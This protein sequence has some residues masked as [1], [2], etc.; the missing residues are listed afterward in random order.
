MRGYPSQFIRIE[1]DSA[2]LERGQLLISGRGMAGERF[3]DLPWYEPHGFAGH[4][5]KGAVGYMLAPGGRREQSIIMAATD[6]A[7]RPG[8]A[9]G[10]AALYDAHGNVIRLFSGGATFDFESRT[11]TLTAGQWT[12]VGPVTIQGDVTV[13]GN[14]HATGSVTDGDGDGGA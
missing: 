14:L 5:R 12:I 13:E 9:A 6:P 8:I 1:V 4:P 2:R 11:V 7:L 3:E 10:D